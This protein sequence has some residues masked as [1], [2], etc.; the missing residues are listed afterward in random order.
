MTSVPFAI[1]HLW[2][3]NVAPVITFAN[4]AV[5]GVWL[6]LTYLRTR[7]LWFPLGVHWSWNWALGSLFGLPVSGLRIGSP[8]LQATDLGPAWLTGGQYGIEGGAAASIA[9]VISIL[10]V[11]KTRLV[12]A[13]PDL[14]DL[15]SHENPAVPPAV[16]S[17]RDADNQ[18]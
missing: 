11:W 10:F 7:S 5:A 6:A 18:T 12:S 13:T 9:L 8:L 16:L 4:T 2:N 14:L 3:P 1:G 15:T 17:I